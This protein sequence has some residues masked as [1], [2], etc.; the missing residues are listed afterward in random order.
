MTKY[1]YRILNISELPPPNSLLKCDKNHFFAYVL[2]KKTHTKLYYETA[3]KKYFE[4]LSKTKHSK[5]QALS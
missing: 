3:T 4:Y 2:L 1:Q 5:P